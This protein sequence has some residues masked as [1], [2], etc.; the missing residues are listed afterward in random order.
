[1]KKV[2]ITGGAGFIGSHVVEHYLKN[3]FSVSVIDN[4]STG[5]IENLAEFESQIEFINAD[6]TWAKHNVLHA[7]NLIIDAENSQMPVE[8][9][10]NMLHFAQKT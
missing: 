10:Q 3:N 5:R 4:L 1:M 6:E 7:E 9:Q 8:N 2:I